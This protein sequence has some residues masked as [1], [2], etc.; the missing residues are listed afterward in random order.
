MAAESSARSLR[1]SSRVIINAK[2]DGRTRS[3]RHYALSSR[4]TAKQCTNDA[5]RAKKVEPIWRNRRENVVPF[6]SLRVRERAPECQIRHYHHY[7]R[8]VSRHPAVRP[9]ISPQTDKL[10]GHPRHPIERP[11]RHP[12][13]P[14][15]RQSSVRERERERGKERGRA[16]S[17]TVGL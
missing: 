1:R 6:L 15:R 8:P 12:Q 14:I 7:R 16:R 3:R 17:V 5:K 4:Q 10:L 11:S 9:S 2:N 13:F